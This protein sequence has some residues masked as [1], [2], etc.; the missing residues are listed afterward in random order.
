MALDDVGV[1]VM[2]LVA[3]CFDSEQLYPREPYK[4]CGAHS[5]TLHYNDRFVAISLGWRVEA[6]IGKA[7]RNSNLH[8]FARGFD[9][10]N[11]AAANAPTGLDVF[12]QAGT[13]K[14]GE[15]PGAK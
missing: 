9:H 15:G 3:V 12:E 5:K 1:D 7:G 14:R 4:V 13:G 2:M 10:T 11:L 8:T 6:C